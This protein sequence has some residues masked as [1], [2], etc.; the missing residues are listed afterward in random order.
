MNELALFA[1]AGGGILGSKLLGHRMI[2]YVEFNE[3]CQKTIRRRIDDGILDNAPIF[4]DIRAFN[5]EGYAEAYQGMVD[6]LTAGFPCQPFSVS[7]PQEGELDPRNMW[8]ETIRSIR[9]IRPRFAYLE[10]VPGL[11]VSGYIRR[12]FGDL[13][14][15][16][17]HTR[18]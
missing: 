14:E 18:S 15:S 11:L 12:I 8:P 9:I 6:V 16:G 1:G 5:G 17:Y 7:G 3:H 4:T 13:A 2:G 10:N